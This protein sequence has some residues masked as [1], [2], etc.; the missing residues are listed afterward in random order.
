[1]KGVQQR[2]MLEL[3]EQASTICSSCGTVL[4]AASKFCNECGAKVGDRVPVAA[5]APAEPDTAAFFLSA[6]E[7]YHPSKLI[8]WLQRRTTRL[9][10]PPAI[11]PTDFDEDLYEALQVDP[12][13]SASEI[14]KAYRQLALLTHPDKPTGDRREFERVSRAYDI[15]SDPRSRETYD[16]KRREAA[17]LPRRPPRIVLRSGRDVAGDVA[18]DLEH[19]GSVVSESLRGLSEKILASLVRE[20]SKCEEAPPTAPAAAAGGGKSKRHRVQTSGADFLYEDPPVRTS[21]ADFL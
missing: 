16:I 12:Q 17:L 6:L 9:E 3:Q 11:G 10:E 7:D 15:L 4:T 5:S 18:K 21:A 2:C 19:A 1:M 13:A 14:R 20:R 8:E